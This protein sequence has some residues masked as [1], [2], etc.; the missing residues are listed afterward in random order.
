M[1]HKIGDIVLGTVI[2]VKPFALFLKFEEGEQGLLH[3]SE[4]SDDFVRDIEKFGSVGD[5]MKVKVLSIDPSNGFM[6]VSYKQVPSNES[7][8]SHTND[9]RVN[10]V[11]DSS[12]FKKL[13]EKL[14]EW[15]KA[16]LEKEEKKND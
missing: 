6:R 4:I 7:Y 8:S 11:D 14:P 13:E 9:K 2:N 12:D 16:T 5:Q 1:D 15:I 10:L 3:I